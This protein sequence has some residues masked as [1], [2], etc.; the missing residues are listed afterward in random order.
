MSQRSEKNF[1]IEDFKGRSERGVKER[2]EMKEIVP[3]SLD[4]KSANSS[5]V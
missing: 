2:L 5:F 3:F 1:K 4:K